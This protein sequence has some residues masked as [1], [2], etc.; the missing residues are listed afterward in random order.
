M[1]FK[2]LH[3]Q[4]KFKFKFNN[5]TVVSTANIHMYRPNQYFLPF[6]EVFLA[7]KYHFSVAYVMQSLYLIQYTAALWNFG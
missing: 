2:Y 5:S 1:V 7:G 4:W 3:V 6:T